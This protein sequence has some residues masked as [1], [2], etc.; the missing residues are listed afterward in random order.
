MKVGLVGYKNHAFR[1][2]QV[3][4]RQPKI[5]RIFVYHPDAEKIAS[6]TQKLSQIDAR[7]TCTSDIR[8]IEACQATIIASPPETHLFYIELLA[9]TK[10]YL[11]CEKPPI[12]SKLDLP[13]LLNII[14]SM[15]GKLAFHFNQRFGSFFLELNARIEDKSLGRLVS[16][17]F[18]N[19]HGLAFE[20]K[21]QG[22]RNSNDNLGIWGNLAIHYVDMSCAVG[23]AP[24]AVS[25]RGYRHSAKSKKYDTLFANLQFADFEASIFCSYAAPCISQMRAVF[26]DGILDFTNGHLTIASPRRSFDKDGRFVPPQ[27]RTI[28]RVESMAQYLNECFEKS[29]ASFIGDSSSE[30]VFSNTQS[31]IISTR[32]IFESP[33]IEQ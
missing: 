19:S 6:V 15:N 25:S 3:L 14:D 33:P 31:S 8:N 7:I 24:R 32:V 2:L 4:T 13:K 9:P 28:S 26:E 21:F 1:L 30:K 16:L 17:R 27:T 18:E 20:D 5:N 10:Q 22:W 12:S 11:L 23:G 29:V